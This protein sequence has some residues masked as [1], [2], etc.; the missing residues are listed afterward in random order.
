MSREL[1]RQVNVKFSQRT[2]QKVEEISERLNLRV[3]D[4]VRRAVTEGLRAFDHAK[5]PGSS[6]SM[7]G[8]S[9]EDR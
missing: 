4:V 7:G 8:K 6:S 2:Y 9:V 5:L 1:E 3:S